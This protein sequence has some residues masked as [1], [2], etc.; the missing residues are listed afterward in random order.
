MST[1]ERQRVLRIP[2]KYI[3]MN[4]ITSIITQ[5]Y[6]DEDYED[7]FSWYLEESFP[8]IFDYAKVG[9]FQIAPTEESFIDYVLERELDASGEYGKTRALNKN[10]KEKY[11]LVFQQIDPDINMDYV[12]LVEFCWY[13][14]TEAPNYYDYAKDS[15]YDEV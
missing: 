12:R 8:D 3:N 9:R 7:D 13:N 1:Y 5:K 14:G 4:Y 15:F 11:H 2:M 10:E 6:P